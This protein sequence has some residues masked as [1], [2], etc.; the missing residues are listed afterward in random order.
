MSTKYAHYSDIDK[1]P[2]FDIND[3]ADACSIGHQDRKSLFK[4]K[5]LLL[6]TQ[7]SQPKSQQYA[8]YSDR[9]IPFIS[10]LLYFIV[11]L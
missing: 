4:E 11:F 7:W 5:A 10:L 9:Q 8:H 1:I 6:F 3:S 2:L